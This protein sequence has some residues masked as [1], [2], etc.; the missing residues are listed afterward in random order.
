MQATAPLM[1]SEVLGLGFRPLSLSDLDTLGQFYAPLHRPLA[2]LNAVMMV[3][4]RRAL[5]LH[6][7]IEDK[8]LYLLAD[9]RGA[10]TLW[11]PPIGERVAIDHV[12]RAFQL[13]REL[14]PENP[15]P[16]IL[17]VW[18][19]YSLWQ[20]LMKSP[21]FLTFKQATEYVYDVSRVAA[22][23]GSE[24]KKKRRD[25]LYF[26][27][28]YEPDIVEYSEELAP[29]CLRLLDKWV[30]RKSKVVSGD[31]RRKFCV[32]WKVCADALRERLPLTGVVAIIAGEVHAFSIGGPH[33]RTSFNC[34]FEKTNLDIPESSAF[35]FAEL[36]KKCAVSY[37]E[38]NVGEDWGIG[39]LAFSKQL[40]RPTRKQT[41]YCLQEN[42]K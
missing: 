40:W 14:D 12:R 35:I 16:E 29:N 17:Y 21:D 27:K 19:N 38:I 36:A 18:E 33:G 9:W 41:S 8:V 4:W 5:D 11:G 23:A 20:E 39:Y 7:L 24:Y 30:E 15:T 34:I 26:Q 2:D 13:L 10:L 3:A 28:T 32:E 22:L 25:Y 37:S 42:V 6:L 1:R 31:D